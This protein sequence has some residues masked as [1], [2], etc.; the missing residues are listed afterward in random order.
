MPLG[1]LVIWYYWV[2]GVIGLMVFLDVC[3]YYEYGVI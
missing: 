1:I 3:Y 2:Y